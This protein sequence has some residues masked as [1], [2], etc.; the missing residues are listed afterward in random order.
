MWEEGQVFE[1]PEPTYSLCGGFPF[2]LPDIP[3][4]FRYTLAWTEGAWWTGVHET[5]AHFEH[6]LLHSRRLRP[7]NVMRRKLR[8]LR[9]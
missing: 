8:R 9:N 6:G 5:I 2:I 1:W 3:G 4:G 7:G